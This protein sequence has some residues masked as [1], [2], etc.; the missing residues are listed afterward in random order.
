MI[1]RTDNFLILITLP[2]SRAAFFGIGIYSSKGKKWSSG[3]GWAEQS[4]A[5]QH[6]D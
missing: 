3:V 5:K 6:C 2:I 4:E 1:H